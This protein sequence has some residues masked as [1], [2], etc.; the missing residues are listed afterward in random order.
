[1]ITFHSSQSDCARRNRE[2]ESAGTI[3]FNSQFASPICAVMFTKHE[4]SDATIFKSRRSRLSLICIFIHGHA[5]PLSFVRF[6]RLANS[7]P[8]IQR[9]PARRSHNIRE[10]SHKKSGEMS[11]SL[12]HN[13]PA[14]AG[15]WQMQ[16]RRMST[17]AACKTTRDMPRNDYAMSISQSEQ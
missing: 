11:H 4:K 8:M 9:S 2:N 14:I 15:Q 16:R 13:F 7:S 6:L 17:Q 5:L 10:P 12:P 3:N 1:M